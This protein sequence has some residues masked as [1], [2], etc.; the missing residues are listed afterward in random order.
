[1]PRISLALGQDGKPLLSDQSLRGQGSS[2]SPT[3]L[4]ITRCRV[5]RE[6]FPDMSRFALLFTEQEASCYLPDKEF[7]SELLLATMWLRPALP[8]GG[9]VISADL[10]MSPCSSDY[11]FLERFSSRPGV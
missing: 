4:G 11:I 10:C 8:A 9:S 5:G 6:G 7:R 2:R 1:M 3:S